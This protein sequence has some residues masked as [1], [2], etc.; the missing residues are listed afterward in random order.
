MEQ[1]SWSYKSSAF[2][3]DILRYDKEEGN[4]IERREIKIVEYW[5]RK[6]KERKITTS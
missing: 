2:M 3:E 4:R 1:S 5:K 6:Y